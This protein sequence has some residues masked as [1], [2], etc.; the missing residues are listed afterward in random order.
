MVSIEADDSQ[1]FPRNFKMI[2]DAGKDVWMVGYKGIGR[3]YAYWSNFN[4]DGVFVQGA[5]F[6]KETDLSKG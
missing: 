4:I 6:I 2:K 3:E 1:E 5:T